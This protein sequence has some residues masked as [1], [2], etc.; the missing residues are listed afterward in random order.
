M[1]RILISG[2][3]GSG[4][5]HLAKYFKYQGLNAIDA[6]L[7]YGLGEYY[8][9]EGKTVDIPEGTDMNFFDNHSFLWDKLTLEELLKKQTA[10]LYLFGWAGN[11][12][13]FLDYFDKY[14]YLDIPPEVIMQ[15]LASDNRENPGGMGK[16]DEQRRLVVEFVKSTQRP[17]SLE[18]GFVFV[19]ST[20]TPEELFKTIT[21]N[22]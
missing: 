5:T 9:S 17:E 19:D 10:D 7:V 20:K 1:K 4:K 16:T 6:D 15:R 3:S 21:T 18:N 22:S 11:I 8:D 13:D 12:N 14:F 2:P